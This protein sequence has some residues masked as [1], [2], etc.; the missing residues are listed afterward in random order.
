MTEGSSDERVRTSKLPPAFDLLAACAGEAGQNPFLFERAGIGVASPSMSGGTGVATGS[1]TPE[2]IAGMGREM[3]VQL[4]E[5]AADGPGPLAVGQI[6][7]SERGHAWMRAPMRLVRRAGSGEPWL[8]ELVSSDGDVRPFA[9]VRPMGGAPAEPFPPSQV[10]PLP[11]ADGYQAMVSTAAQR[12]REGTMR[13]VV[14]ARTMQVEAGRTLDPVRLAHRLRAV[15]PH[16]FTFI[17]P[18]GPDASLVGASPE[19]LVAK[20]GLDVRSTPLAGSAPRSGDPEEDRANANA[21]LAS[22]KDREEH[23]IVVEAIEDVLGTYCERLDHDR[24][25]VLVETANVWHLA[26]RFEGRLRD[27][28]P[29]VVELVA[30]LHPTP[31]VGGTPTAVAK[32]AIDELEPFDRGGYAGAVGWMDAGGDGEWAIALRCARLDGQRATLYAGAGIVADS[33]PAAELDET[34]RKFRAF[35]DSLRWG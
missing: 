11:P 10:T 3:I 35:L 23:A 22:A 7:F 6:P 19:L 1:A 14:L 27:P 5:L 16:A 32:A 12:I 25:P 26:T 2:A 4:R 15:D 17:T 29:S 8:I 20:R 13:K 31:A 9:P 24:E 33:R 28:S 34:D 30:A 18:D 21:L